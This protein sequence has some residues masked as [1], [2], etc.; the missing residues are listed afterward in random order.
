MDNV[1]AVGGS[2]GV[3]LFGAVSSYKH[4]LGVTL[5]A[6]PTH[7]RTECGSLLHVSESGTAVLGVYA[8][9][10]GPYGDDLAILKFELPG[11]RFGQPTGIA[12][13]AIDVMDNVLAVGGS[14]GVQLFDVFYPNKPALRAT[15]TNSVTD[16]VLDGRRLVSVEQN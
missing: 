1:L 12:A 11:Q 3:Q 2:D 4:I 16:L 14:D 13:S 8:Y 9:L 15:L 7:L 5:P 10:P 6:S